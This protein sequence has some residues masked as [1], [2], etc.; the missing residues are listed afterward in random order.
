[1]RRAWARLWVTMTTVS[2]SLERAD[3]VLDDTRGDGIERAARFVEEDD[4]GIEGQGPGDAEALLLPSGEGDGALVEPVGDLA[5]ESDF[6]EDALYSVGDVA[7]APAM[8]LQGDLEIPPDRLG[9]GIG[10]LKDDADAATQRQD[11]GFGVGDFGAV[12]EVDRTGDA[13]AGNEI[14]EPVEAVEEAALA[15]SRG[16]DE[17][18]DFPSGMFRWIPRTAAK[19]R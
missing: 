4:L 1:M 19:S 11:V 7:F 13:A 2:L 17:G 6:A 5:P 12:A 8:L 3:Q 15:A 9:K 18:G 14:G 16:A 10:P